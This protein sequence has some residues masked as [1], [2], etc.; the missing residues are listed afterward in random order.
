M[1]HYEAIVLGTGGVGSAALYELAR[2]GVRALGLDRFEPGHDRGSSHGVTRIM[3]QAYYEHPDYVPLV[4]LAYRRWAELAER[5]RE[6]LYHEVGLVQVGPP[7]G[8]V[9]PGVLASAQAHGLEVEELSAREIESRWSGFRV[10]APLAGVFERRAGY[11]RVEE[12]VRAH[13][14]EALAL[15][16]QLHTGLTVRRWQ[17]TGSSVLV[18]T[19]RESYAAR[20]LIVA[21]GAWARELVGDLGLRLEV[22][23][24]PVF[25]Y[26][27]AGSAYRADRGCPC[28]L[29]ET[30][31]GIF[32]GV[33]E[34]DA[35][36]VKVAEHTGGAPVADPL[37]VNRDM[38]PEERA[39]IEAFLS[40]CLPQAAGRLTRHTVCMY[41]MTPDAHFVVD[42]HPAWPQVVFAAGLS[43]H[44]FKFTG[45]LGEA[46]ADLALE[47][48]TSLPIGFL[49]ADRAG[50]H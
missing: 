14:A 2:R 5:R 11:L 13:I 30:A 37:A 3:R 19:D 16:A 42:R 17:V 36:G 33:P 28:F 46:L 4:L 6:A 1:L 7:D 15:G 43:G 48:R 21:A 50:M 29:Y 34:I 35:W 40:T 8:E 25:W 12:C 47:G 39:R 45:V 44:G 27:T 41:T 24:K 49:A 26:E 23:R 32:Y 9:L 18:E 20:W 10:H 38:D 22:R 31:A